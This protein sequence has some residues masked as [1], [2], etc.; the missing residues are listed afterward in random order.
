MD[1]WMDLQAWITIM[2]GPT[3]AMTPLIK[4]N[5]RLTLHS[6]TRRPKT[7]ALLHRRKHTIPPPAR[8]LVRRHTINTASEVGPG[9]VFDRGGADEVEAVDGGGAAEHFAAGPGELAGVD[10][11]LGDGCV[12]PVV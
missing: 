2:H 9:V 4:L 12:G 11:G 10:V 8:H 5:P 3:L 1:G 6:T 7:L